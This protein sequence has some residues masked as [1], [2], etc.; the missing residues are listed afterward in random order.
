MQGGENKAAGACWLSAGKGVV[1]AVADP[2]GRTSASEPKATE[3]R[4]RRG[5][6]LRAMIETRGGLARLIHASGSRSLFLSRDT[7]HEGR[8]VTAMQPHRTVDE[9]ATPQPPA[10]TP[11]TAPVVPQRSSRRATARRA[12]NRRATARLHQRRH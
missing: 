7:L 1:W 6:E 11:V 12:S 9:A 10:S 5:A 2:A 3:A 8:E 4:P